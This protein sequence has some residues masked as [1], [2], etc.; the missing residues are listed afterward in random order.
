MKVL[1][2]HDLKYFIE[3]NLMSLGNDLI[4]KTTTLKNDTIMSSR[5][6]ARATKF[7]MSACFI[8]IIFSILNVSFNIN[9]SQFTF[10]GYEDKRVAYK[11]NPQ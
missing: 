9:K 3:I 1:M 10:C 6:T 4:T 2:Y 5:T 11:K 8:N 7:Y